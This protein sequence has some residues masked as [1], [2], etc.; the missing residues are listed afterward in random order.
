MSFSTSFSAG[1]RQSL[2]FLGELTEV[3]MAVRLILS[4]GLFP[5]QS[6]AESEGKERREDGQRAVFAKQ[7]K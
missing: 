2:P 7:F 3:T 4:S 5:A 6:R 1:H